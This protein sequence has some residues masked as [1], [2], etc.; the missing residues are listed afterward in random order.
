MSS[1]DTVANM[2]SEVLDRRLRS[3]AGIYKLGVSLRGAKRVGKVEEL[4][5]KTGRSDAVVGH[6]PSREPAGP[7]VSRG[8][9]DHG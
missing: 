8:D 5:A 2:T 6:A 9:D 3:L 4:K 1:K 7:D